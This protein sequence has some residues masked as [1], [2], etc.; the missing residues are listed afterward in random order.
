[1][2]ESYIILGRYLPHYKPYSDKTECWVKLSLS[3]RKFYIKKN[4]F[5]EDT[6]PKIP[7]LPKIHK[8][9][10]IPSGLLGFKKRWREQYFVLV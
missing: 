9:P 3:S 8:L 7:T 10:K 6:L 2:L 1:M 5:K 4:F